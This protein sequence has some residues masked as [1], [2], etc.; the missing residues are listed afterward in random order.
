MLHQVSL[1]VA[2]LPRARASQAPALAAIGWKRC[3]SA[4]GVDADRLRD[5]FRGNRRPP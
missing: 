5:Y 3:I 1:L 4:E 2:D